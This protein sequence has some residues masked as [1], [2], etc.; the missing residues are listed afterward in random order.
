MVK[1]VVSFPENEAGLV[2][3]EAGLARGMGQ[4]LKRL[5]RSAGC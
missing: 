5:T 2:H 4:I 3:L 1:T